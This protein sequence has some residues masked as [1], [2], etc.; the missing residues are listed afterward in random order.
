MRRFTNPDSPD[1]DHDAALFHLE[2]AAQCGVPEARSA[3]AHLLLG[4][5]HDILPDL[6]VQK[7]NCLVFKVLKCK[8]MQLPSS[9]DNK[10]KGF[11]LMMEA[12]ASGDID[13]MIF[14]G[15]AFDSGFLLGTR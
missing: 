5:Q 11:N 2:Y 13:A 3:H 15:K 9:D 7:I 8:F 4:L 10:D 6:E 14:V 12:A 1:Y